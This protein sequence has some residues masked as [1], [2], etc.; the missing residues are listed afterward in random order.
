MVELGPGVCKRVRERYAMQREQ[1]APKFSWG[2]AV[3]LR[4]LKSVE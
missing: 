1:H 4:E 3:D 2:P